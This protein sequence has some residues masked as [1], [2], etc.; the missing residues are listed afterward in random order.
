MYEIESGVPVPASA[1]QGISAYPF[2]VMQVGQSF[3]VPITGT[4]IQTDGRIRNAIQRYVKQQQGAVKFTVRKDGN[5]I[6]IWR[7]A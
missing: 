2:A 3:C 4:R 1:R 5:S 6:R 7:V